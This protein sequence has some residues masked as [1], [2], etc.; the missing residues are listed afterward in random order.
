M[1]VTVERNKP[2]WNCMKATMKAY[3]FG[4]ALGLLSGA[5]QMDN[6]RLT[7]KDNINICILGR[8]IMCIPENGNQNG[9]PMYTPIFY[10]P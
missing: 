4:D 10:L 3:I 2:V 5:I 1:L 8:K 6:V 9:R 7:G